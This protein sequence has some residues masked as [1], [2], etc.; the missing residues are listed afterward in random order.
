M[1]LLRAGQGFLCS[2]RFKQ[3]AQSRGF[4]S[5]SFKLLLNLGECDEVVAEERQHPL[6]LRLFLCKLLDD[7]LAAFLDSGGLLSS[8]SELHLRL[9][10]R[11]AGILDERSTVLPNHLF[12]RVC[13]HGLATAAV[14]WLRVQRGT[15]SFAGVHEVLVPSWTNRAPEVARAAVAAADKAAQQILPRGVLPR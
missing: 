3:P 9:R 1:R 8:R 5:D 2:Q 15:T 14:L 12:E 11:L 13:L 6:T 10:Q 4:C 7:V